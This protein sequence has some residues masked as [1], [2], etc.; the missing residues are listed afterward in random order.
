MPTKIWK[1]ILNLSIYL[2][3]IFMR[4]IIIVLGLKSVFCVFS[5][6]E[7]ILINV[8]FLSNFNSFKF[9]NTS[10]CS[11][12]NMKHSGIPCM[13]VSICSERN[14]LYSYRRPVY[15]VLAEGQGF[16][17]LKFTNWFTDYYLFDLN[18]RWYTCF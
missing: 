10:L 5:L 1:D 6:A 14:C 3:S 16:H 12:E 7:W 8:D 15:L 11:K 9:E 18:A 17:Y 13:P 2:I 4:T